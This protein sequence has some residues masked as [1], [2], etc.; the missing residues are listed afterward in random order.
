MSERSNLGNGTVEIGTLNKDTLVSGIPCAGGGDIRLNQSGRAVACRLSADWTLGASHL[1]KGDFFNGRLTLEDTIHLKDNVTLTA[2]IVDIQNN[3]LD[4][5]SDQL[6]QSSS[7]FPFGNMGTPKIHDLR[8]QFPGPD[9]ILTHEELSVENLF[10]NPPFADCDGNIAADTEIGWSISYELGTTYI[11]VWIR[12]LHGEISHHFCPGTSTL[13]AVGAIWGWLKGDISSYTVGG[14]AQS[15]ATKFIAGTSSHKI[16]TI[17]PAMIAKLAPLIAL[18]PT[19]GQQAKVDP[20]SL[21]L[22]RLYV[23]AGQL[24]LDYTYDAE[25]D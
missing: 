14:R 15:L 3:L 19:A 6:L 4:E 25:L 20:S 10:T 24:I 1:Q 16:E 5:L 11:A 8:Q 18:L 21:R 17:K 13:E 12:H 9:N 23:D 2:S 7:K 22:K